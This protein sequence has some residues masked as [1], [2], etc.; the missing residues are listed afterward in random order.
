[1]TQSS[2]SVIDHRE[3]YSHIK[4]LGNQEQPTNCPTCTKVIITGEN[5]LFW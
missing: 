4:G 3:R 2:S 1:M 5:V